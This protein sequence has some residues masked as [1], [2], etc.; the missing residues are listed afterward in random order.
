MGK[1]MSKNC[2]KKRNFLQIPALENIVF[3]HYKVDVPNVGTVSRREIDF[4]KLFL[5][6]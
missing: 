5:L 1:K 3:D 4:W 6:L 2:K